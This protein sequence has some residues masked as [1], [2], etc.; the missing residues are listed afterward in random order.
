[1]LIIK[2][3]VNNV[4][5]YLIFKGKCYKQTQLLLLIMTISLYYWFHFGCMLLSMI[6]LHLRMFL[7]ISFIS[8]NSYDHYFIYQLL[9]LLPARPA[10]L[11]T[12]GVDYLLLVLFIFESFASS[13]Q[14]LCYF[15]VSEWVC[16]I[17]ILRDVQSV[18]C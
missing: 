14:F 3:I 9:S 16:N 10:I 2:C 8:K 1:M 6:I 5:I 15:H 17:E 7:P 12:S 18:V 11:V 13:L 4:V